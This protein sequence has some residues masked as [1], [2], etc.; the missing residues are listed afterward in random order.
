ML[1]ALTHGATDASGHAASA[2]YYFETRR[3]L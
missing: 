3:M 1:S 2:G